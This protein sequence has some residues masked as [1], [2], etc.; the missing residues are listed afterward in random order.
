MIVQ[1]M[2]RHALRRLF[3]FSTH[4]KPDPKSKTG[5]RIR[6]PRDAIV[7]NI[8]PNSHPGKVQRMWRRHVQSNAAAA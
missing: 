3:W 8:G 6:K 5:D 4:T 1:R 7:F 2:N